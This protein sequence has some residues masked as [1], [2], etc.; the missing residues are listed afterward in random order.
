MNE[1]YGPST[2]GGSRGTDTIQYSPPAPEYS[3]PY[4]GYQHWPAGQP[5]AT[6]S[7]ASPP[8][9]IPSG[10]PWPGAAW[11][12]EPVPAPH[13]APRR[14]GLFV[15]IV[16]VVV[17]LMIGLAAGGLAVRAV[18]P[19]LTGWGST[20][21]AGSTGTGGSAGSGESGGLGGSGGAPGWSGGSGNTAPGGSTQ[22]NADLTAIASAVAP[23]IV[24]VY[25]TLGMQ[26]AKG[27]GTG[28][29]LTATGEILTNNH[30][31]A[32]ATSISVTDVGNGRTYPAT[33]VGYSRTEDIAILSLQGA[34]GLPTASIGDS[35]TVRPGDSIVALG[36]A[37]GVGGTPS[38]VAGTVTAIGQEITASDQDGGNAEQLSGLIQVAANIQPGDSGGPLVNSSGQVIGMNTAA[39]TGYQYQAAGGQGFAI[40]ISHAVAVAGDITKGHA[41]STVHLGASAMLGV[42]VT[43]APTGGAAIAS[44]V[45]NAPA[46]QAGLTRGDVIVS[47]D[48]KAVGQSSALTALLDQHHP[49]DKVKIGY[50]DLNGQS[51]T[52]TVTLAA[53]P[54]G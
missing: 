21:G 13:Q 4:Y 34:S 42:N 38:A 47:L 16:V 9:A 14:T 31:V 36:N 23:T 11:H 50:Q 20:A 27:A 19:A 49:G 45:D 33:V 41:S 8:G 26:G 18:W 30:V 43:D 5:G 28:I 25:S 35:S 7:G 32:G 39:S 52:A 51:H 1:Q 46:E 17:L 24:D 10:A 15:G 44:I 3:H 37:G 22:S 2:T 54:V 6:P 12:P 53:G 40:P 48:G 29:V